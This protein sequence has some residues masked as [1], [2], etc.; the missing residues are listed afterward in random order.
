MPKHKSISRREL[1]RRTGALAAATGALSIASGCGPASS[2]PSAE[3]PAVLRDQTPVDLKYPAVPP[4]PAAPPEPGQLRVFSMQEART[5]EALTARIMPGTPDDPGAREAGVVVYIDHML[6]ANEGFAEP[7]YRQPPFAQV[8]S[9]DSPPANGD[10]YEVIWVPADLIARYGFQAVLS[11]REV[12]RI[13]LEAVDR[14]ARSRFTRDFADLS[15]SEQD[16]IVGDMAEGRATGFGQVSAEQFFL[17]LRRHTAE[18][19]FSDP[20]YGGNR[21]MAGWELVGF[22]GA[23]RAWTIAELQT[24][25]ARR[26]PQAQAHLPPLSPG[27]DARE[28]V[29]LPLSGSDPRTWEDAHQ[30]AP[31]TLVPTLPPGSE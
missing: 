6:A 21:N 16:T 13:G 29:V 28:G 14:Y 20:A 30:H 23:Q 2:P 7:T 5:V 12:Y 4:A 22:P 10:L 15:E 26:S 9:G 1:I 25:G 11:P 18:G 27:Q 17:V 8:Y 31:P 24:E 3:L 19:M